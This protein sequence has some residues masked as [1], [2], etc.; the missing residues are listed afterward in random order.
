MSDQV[1]DDRGYTLEVVVERSPSEVFAAVVDVRGWWSQNIQGDTETAGD[2]FIYRYKDVHCCRV[3]VTEAV[4]GERV[5]WRILENYFAFTAD[6]SEWTGTTVVFDITPAEG[7]TRLRFMHLGL[8]ADHECFEVC[9]DAWRFYIT[10]SLRQLID[11]GVGQPNP[12][13]QQ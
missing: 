3:Q 11:S 2:E 10:D 6:Q 5:A 12:K 4:P 9:S 7:G 1:T 8:L 13:E